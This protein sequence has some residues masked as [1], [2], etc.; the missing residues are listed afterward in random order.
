MSCPCH[1]Q[2]SADLFNNY[3]QALC[4]PFPRACHRYHSTHIWPKD[5]KFYSLREGVRN[6]AHWLHAFKQSYLRSWTASVIEIT[7]ASTVDGM[8]RKCLRVYAASSPT[9]HEA[10][11]SNALTIVPLLKFLTS[12]VFYHK[13]PITATETRILTE[14]YRHTGISKG[15]EATKSRRITASKDTYIRA[16]RI[17][18]RRLHSN[19]CLAF[20]GQRRDGEYTLPAADGVLWYYANTPK[21]KERVQWNTAHSLLYHLS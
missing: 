10:L 6:P 5:T 4:I 2:L 18:A 19:S 13:D 12:G 15:S 8:I 9:Q 14:I 1:Q 3:P 20:W 17:S 16:L 21:C 7:R 11:H